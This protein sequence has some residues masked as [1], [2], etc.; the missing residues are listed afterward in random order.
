MKNDWAGFSESNSVWRDSLKNN[1]HNE[2]IQ[3]LENRES[4]IVNLE[5]TLHRV[6]HE[7]SQKLE[8]LRSSMLKNGQ[9]AE[10]DLQ[11]SIREIRETLDKR[12][13]EQSAASQDDISKSESIRSTIEAHLEQVRRQLES[14]SS[15]NPE[16]QLLREALLEEQRC[17]H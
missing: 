13:Q 9:Q 5:E 7:W 10:K 2:I 1:L 6:S 11:M 8:G 15:G 14:V 3:Q 17:W 12:F 16:S 4:K